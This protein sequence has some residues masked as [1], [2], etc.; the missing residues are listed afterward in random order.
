MKV[1]LSQIILGGSFFIVSV[2]AFSPLVLPQNGLSLPSTV[3]RSVL[4]KQFATVQTSEATKAKKVVQEQNKNDGPKKVGVNDVLARFESLA[5][6]KTR[7]LLDK[8]WNGQLGKKDALR[9][10]GIRMRNKV[11]NVVPIGGRSS[12][13]MT[14]AMTSGVDVKSSAMVDIVAAGT[15]KKSTTEAEFITGGILSAKEAEE[16]EAGWNQRGRGSAIKRTL[17]IWAFAIKYGLRELKTKKITD[18][19]ELSAARRSNAIFLRDKLLKLG[20][21]FIKLGQLLSTRID[22]FPQEYIEELRLLQDN[23]PGFSGQKAIQIIEEDFDKPIDQ[24]FEKFDVTPI[25]AAS[26]G[27]VHLARLDGETVAVK[28][29]RQGLTELFN[30]DLKNL[31]LLAV[32]LD[33]ADPKSDGADRDWVSIYEES[34]KLLY[35]EIDYE[36]EAKN[37]Q[38]F[39]DNFKSVDW[40]KVP[41]IK[42]GLVSKRVLTMEYVPGVKINDIKE[43]ERRGINRDLLAARSAESYLTQLCRYGFF[44]CD[45]HPGNIACDEKYGG[46]LIYYD[47]GMMDEFTVETR[48]GLVDL[49]FS[50]Y[51]NDAKGTC[52]ALERMEILKRGSDRISVERIARFF[53]GSFQETMQG[54]GD[55]EKNLSKEE[56]KQIRRDRRAKLGE[57]LL[58]VGNDVPFKFPPT[59]TFV[60]RAFTSLDGIGKGLDPKYDLTKL[61]QPYLKELLELR[62]GSASAALVNTWAKR[63]G[64][65]PEDIASLVQNPRNVQYVTDVTRKLEQGDLKL[66][67]RVLESER[68]F[69]RLDMVQGALAAAVLAGSFA[70]AGLILTSLPASS[71]LAARACFALASVFGIQVP[72]TYLKLKKLDK[73]N[74]E[75]GL[76]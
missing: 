17:E 12:V 68:A 20:P 40:V 27:Q 75:L 2:C 3:G 5:E 50:I 8:V 61:A 69:A 13:L 73:K 45:P 14:S 70:N 34:A 62:D 64:W 26:L 49:I 10:Y 53:L 39:N 48:K 31:K 21:T 19:A 11:A 22:L 32:L 66:R 54:G 60:F 28:I 57:D 46:R 16:M 4:T 58:S 36:N 52:N 67:V 33:K 30:Q 9:A 72:L 55:N 42:W 44:H 38:L 71:A 6:Q 23:V 74:A 24:I 63:L 15:K 7:E 76:K 56:A 65:R 43:I 29:Q 37:A 59:F 51:D 47:F 35:K 25:A 41:E 18:K 1:F